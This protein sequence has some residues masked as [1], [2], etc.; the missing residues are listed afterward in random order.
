MSILEASI[1]VLLSLL[2]GYA[3]GRWRSYRDMQLDCRNF[4]K[5]QKVNLVAL[6]VFDRLYDSGVSLKE[7]SKKL[8]YS[9]NDL[10]RI[11]IGEPLL[12]PVELE[13]IAKELGIEKADLIKGGVNGSHRDL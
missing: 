1:Y 11:L 5:S 3:I 10:Y 13:K 12:P 2:A 8:E 6:N 4:L 7:F 9:E